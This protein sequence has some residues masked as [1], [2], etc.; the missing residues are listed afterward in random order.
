MRKIWIILFCAGLFPF[1]TKGQ[2]MFVSADSLIFY[3]LFGTDTTAKMPLRKVV[4]RYNADKQLVER[5]ISIWEKF[6]G[7]WLQRKRFTLQYYADEIMVEYFNNESG[8]QEI[9]GGRMIL[10]LDKQDHIIECSK[11]EKDRYANK[12]TRRS[13]S[14]FSYKSDTMVK[15]SFFEQGT[16]WYKKS[17]VTNQFFKDRIETTV[18]QFAESGDPQDEKKTQ[19]FFQNNRLLYCKQSNEQ[20]S[21]LRIDSLRYHQ[22]TLVCRDTYILAA[23]A[24]AMLEHR[25][26]AV[27]LNG[28][29][30]GEV[31]VFYNSNQKPVADSRNEYIQYLPARL[32]VNSTPGLFVTLDKLL[33]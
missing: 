8:R 32:T 22:D 27:Y 24:P 18:K 5:R 6:S 11:L 20:G 1:V 29:L 33:E 21:E 28:A 31:D 23:K 30:C 13:R 7:V 9:Q 15:H 4:N 16:T 26:Q 2:A 25:M 3:T 10:L 19:M 14:E 12:F 17:E